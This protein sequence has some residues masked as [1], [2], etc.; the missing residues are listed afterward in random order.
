MADRVPIPVIASG[1]VGMLQHLYEGVA[2]GGADV[3]AWPLSIFHFGEFA[4]GAGARLSTRP[5]RARARRHVRLIE[6][7][8]DLRELLWRPWV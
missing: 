4:M 6:P 3:V 5:R 7:V 8:T 2:I 1:V